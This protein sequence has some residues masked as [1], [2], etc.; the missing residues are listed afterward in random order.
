MQETRNA[1]QQ[2][3]QSTRDSQFGASSTQAATAGDKGNPATAHVVDDF[4]GPLHLGSN[5]V[6]G[7]IL[8][9]CCREREAPEGEAVGEVLAEEVHELPVVEVHGLAVPEPESDV[10]EVDVLGQGEVVARVKIA[11]RRRRWVLRHRLPEL[12]AESSVDGRVQVGERRLRV[13]QRPVAPEQGW[14]ERKVLAVDGD[15]NEVDEVEVGSG[16]YL[17]K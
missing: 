6:P 16:T 11:E 12:V 13:D 2:L 15:V 4:L 17:T 10:R 5:E 9:G 3:G 14:R 7:E 8:V 1:I